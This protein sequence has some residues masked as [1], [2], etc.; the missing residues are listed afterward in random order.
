M[1]PQPE[2]NYLELGN[3]T[4]HL[5]VNVRCQGMGVCLTFNFLQKKKG[6]EG[7]ITLFPYFVLLFLQNDHINMLL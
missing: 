5:T 2:L 7:A 4:R 3:V 1:L 6:L